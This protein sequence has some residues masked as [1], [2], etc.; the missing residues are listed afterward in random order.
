MTAGQ[1]PDRVKIIELVS[2]SDSRGELVVAELAELV[3]FNCRR[4]FIVKHVPPDVVRG[5]HAHRD[6]HQLLIA[7]SGSVVVEV[8]DGVSRGEVKLDC[9]QT[10]LYL[11]PMT[12][13][14]QRHYSRDCS[15]IVLASHPYDP[16]D[17]IHERKEFLALTGSRR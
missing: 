5:A 3:P 2:Q 12:W 7:A 4:I 13:A 9:P 8:D 11:P 6:C 1:I 17:Y 15:L 10:A 16:A 14:L